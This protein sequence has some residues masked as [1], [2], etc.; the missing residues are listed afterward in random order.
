MFWLRKEKNI[1]FN[2]TFS[3]RSLHC[4]KVRVKS[5]YFGHQVNSDI[6]TFTNSKNPDEKAPYEPSHQDVHCLPS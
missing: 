4:G 3:S 6:R 5:G 1:V 2:Y